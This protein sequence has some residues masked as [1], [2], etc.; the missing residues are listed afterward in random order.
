LTLRTISALP[1]TSSAVG[2]IVAPAYRNSSS[3]IDEPWPA[4]ASMTTS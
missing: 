1:H 3:V 2:R 4:P